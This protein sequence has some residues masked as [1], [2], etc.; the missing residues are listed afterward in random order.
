MVRGQTRSGPGVVEWS[1]PDEE[2]GDVRVRLA[3]EEDDL[4]PDEARTTWCPVCDQR[5]AMR[6]VVT[7]SGCRYDLCD[8]CGLLLHVDRAHGYVTAHRVIV[9]RQPADAGAAAAATSEQD[10]EVGPA[11]P[12]TAGPADRG[13]RPHPRTG[14]QARPPAPVGRR[15]RTGTH[16]RSQRPRSPGTRRP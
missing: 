10:H 15:G 1:L 9:P 13:G 2:V 16:R 12:A 8:G 7:S 11:A 6:A 3:F 5:T 14:A 4:D